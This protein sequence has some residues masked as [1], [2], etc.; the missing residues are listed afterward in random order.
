METSL[1]VDDLSASTAFYQ[2]VFGFAINCAVARLVALV[3]IPSQTQ[4]L[5]TQAM[6]VRILPPISMG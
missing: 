2:R 4:L 5:F 3:S 6:A 1:Y